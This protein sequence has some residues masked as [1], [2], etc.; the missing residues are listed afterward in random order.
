[1]VPGSDWSHPDLDS[2]PGTCLILTRTGLIL[3]RTGAMRPGR[4]FK[5]QR[6]ASLRP[7][8]QR[9]DRPPPPPTFAPA[10]C[11]T[12]LRG[13]GGTGESVA[14]RTDCPGPGAGLRA[15]RPCWPWISGPRTLCHPARGSPCQAGQA[16][17][18]PVQWAAYLA[19]SHG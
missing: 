15:A 14:I 12:G 9:A 10:L 11:L 13:S 4:S 19:P 5:F 8:S 6:P 16:G 3:T 18:C 7:V 17:P 1:M 2:W